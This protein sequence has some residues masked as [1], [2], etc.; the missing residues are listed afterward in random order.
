MGEETSLNCPIDNCKELCGDGTCDDYICDV[1][2]GE[3]VENCPHDCACNANYDCEPWEDAKHCPRDCGPKAWY[4]QGEGHDANDGEDGT[5][6]Q[7]DG[8]NGYG[9]MNSGSDESSTSDSE[10]L[11]NDKPCVSHDDCCSSA[12]DTGVDQPICVG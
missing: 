3:S 10:C 11:D 7:Y 9:D 4:G 12:C 6:Q 5:N 2:L 1:G 8:S